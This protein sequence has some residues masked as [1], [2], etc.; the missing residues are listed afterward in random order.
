[1]SCGEVVGFADVFGKIEEF[2]RGFIGKSEFGFHGFL[3]AD[4]NRP[5]DVLLVVLPIKVL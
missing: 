4:L 3:I 2:G 5:A 1:M